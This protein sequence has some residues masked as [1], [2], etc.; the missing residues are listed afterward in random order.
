M[1][2]AVAEAARAFRDREWFDAAER[3]GTFLARNLVRD[4]RV[5]RSWLGGTARVTGFLEDYAALGLGF[6]GLY[7]ATFD[8]P[9]LDRARALADA[10]VRWFWD[11]GDGAFYDTPRDGERLI[12]RPRDIADNATPAGQSLA[13]ELQLFVADYFGDAAARERA[14]RVLALAGPA[15]PRMPVMFGHLLGVAD[16]AVRG[17][18]QVAIT[19]RG[20]D[21]LE[22][23]THT[24]YLPSLVIAGGNGREVADLPMFA[25]RLTDRATAYVCRGYAC[26]VPATDQAALGA[27]LSS[28]SRVQI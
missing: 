16:M 4:G 7:Q 11:D 5:M 13:A 18:I 10:S 6:I 21:A 1:L 9:W 22:R 2:R 23:V 12:T 27:Q 14:D 26:E 19:G 28:A 17:A 20:A 8:R 24:R 15:I 3:A 25:G